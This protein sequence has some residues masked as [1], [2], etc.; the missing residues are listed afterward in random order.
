M[1]FPRQKLIDAREGKGAFMISSNALETFGMMYCSAVLL[2]GDL[3]TVRG[4]VE[5]TPIEVLN[6]ATGPASLVRVGVAATDKGPNKRKE[7]P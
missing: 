4:R 2:T 3:T 7:Q 1:I 6:P 5:T